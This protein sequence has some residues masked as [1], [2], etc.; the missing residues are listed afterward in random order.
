MNTEPIYPVNVVVNNSIHALY[1]ELA[2]R[3]EHVYFGGRIAIFKY[4]DMHQVIAKKLAFCE[5]L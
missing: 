4:N 5:Q 2:S 3:E 1:K